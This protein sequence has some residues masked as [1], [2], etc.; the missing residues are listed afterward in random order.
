MKATIF[1][2][3]VLLLGAWASEDL[4]FA[5]EDDVA[6]MAPSC[7]TNSDCKADWI[8]CCKIQNGTTSTSRC[9]NGNACERRFK[10]Q[11]TA[12]VPPRPVK[13]R[14]DVEADCA[15]ETNTCCCKADETARRGTCTAHL[16]CWH[17]DF[18]CINE[19]APHPEK[20]CT[21]NTDCLDKECCCARNGRARGLCSSEAVCSEVPNGKCLP[22]S[23]SSYEDSS[24]IAP[25]PPRPPRDSSSAEASST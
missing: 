23:A 21:D 2:F 9:A 15:K 18:V 10:G 6:V 19:T 14:C 3:G 22:A 16:L 1:V 12:P 7:D 25:R 5:D 4:G 13:P 20:R 24:S 8:C 11:C 17:K